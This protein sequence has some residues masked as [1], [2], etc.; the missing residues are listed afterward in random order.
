[1]KPHGLFMSRTWG[2]VVALAGAYGDAD[3]PTAVVLQSTDGEPLATLSVNMCEPDA[4]HLS[5]DLPEGVFFVPIWNLSA[6][7]RED[8]LLSGLF[9]ARP[10]IPGAECGFVCAPAWQIVWA[11]A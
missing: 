11:D 9:K 8:A 10:D 2:R 6:G 7:L 1:M 4:S 3:G 5:C